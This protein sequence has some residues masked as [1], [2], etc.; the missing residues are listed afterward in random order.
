MF[1]ADDVAMIGTVVSSPPAMPPS[2]LQGRGVSARPEPAQ[3]MPERAHA[4]G[5]VRD[6]ALRQGPL[7][8]VQNLVQA[9]ADSQKTE[10]ADQSGELT[11]AEEQ[12]VG[13]L[14]ERD[15]EVRRHE[16]AHARAGGAYAS[17]PSYQFQRG[18]DGG[19]YAIGGSVSID[20]SPIAGDPEA[21]LRK[22]EVI[23]RAASAPAEPSGADRS[24]AARANAETRAARAEL[25]QEKR[26]EQQEMHRDPDAA[27]N[28]PGVNATGGEYA[29][30][31]QIYENV[32]AL[33]AGNNENAGLSG[34]HLA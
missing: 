31:S 16:E 34:Q 11:E 18:P 32:S 6:P 9:Q 33:R 1:V 4:H 21:T 5:P 29:R 8:N 28:G 30:S 13:E 26:E 25:A 10:A 15:A 17:A 27:K 7:V 22:M 19:Q 3:V 12:Q 2:A 14:K 24:V 20:V 23:K